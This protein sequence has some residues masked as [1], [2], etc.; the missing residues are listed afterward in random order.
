MSDLKVNKPVLLERLEERILL[1]AAPLATPDPAA[2]VVID[3]DQDFLINEEF[4]FSVTFENQSTTPTAV[5]FQPYVDVIVP[6]GIDIVSTSGAAQVG[7]TLYWDAVDGQWEDASDGSGNAVTDHPITLQPLA[8]AANDGDTL[9]IFEY[10]FGS[11]VPGQPQGE[12]N[13]VAV[14]DADNAGDLGDPA[15]V[16]MALDISA[17]GGFARGD[18]Q[19]FVPGEEIVGCTDTEQVTPQIIELVK[20]SD[21]PEGE[22][23]TGENYPVTFT[24]E[25]DVADG[26]TVNNLSILDTFTPIDGF[27]ITAPV[28]VVAVGGQTPDASSDLDAS[29]GNISIDFA[30]FTAD[31]GDDVV[32]VIVTYTGYFADIVPDDDGNFNDDL[33]WTNDS[34]ASVDFEGSNFVDDDDN[35][36]VEIELGIFKTQKSVAVTNDIGATGAT[37]GDTLTYTLAFQVSDFTSLKNIEFDDLLG[38][39]LTYIGLANAQ[40][41]VTQ[42][43]ITSTGSIV[44]ANQ[45]AT[46]GAAAGTTDIQFR[47]SDQLILDNV[48]PNG[49]LVGGQAVDP[50]NNV[51]ATT[52]FITFEAVILQEFGG[53]VGDSSVDITDVLNNNVSSTVQATDPTGVVDGDIESDTSEVSIQID[54]GEVSKETIAIDGIIGNEVLGVGQPVTYQ[55]SFT[56]PTPDV[57]NFSLID[58]LPLP[59]FNVANIGALAFNATEFDGTVGTLPGIGEYAFTTNHNLG[60]FAGVDDGGEFGASPMLS[61]NTAANTYTFDFGS[62]DSTQTGEVTIELVF[63][64]PSEEVFIADGLLLTNQTLATYNDTITTPVTFDAITQ[65]G[66]AAPDIELTKSVVAVDRADLVDP[67]SLYG[68]SDAGTAPSGSAPFNTAV[69]TALLNGDAID[70]DLTGIDAGDTV[71]FAIVLHNTGALDAHDLVIS[72]LLP[73]G[74]DAPAGNLNLEIYNGAGVELTTTSANPEVDLF[75]AGIDIV[76][77]AG[78]APIG[79]L[80]AGFETMLTLDTMDDVENITGSNIIIITYDLVASADIQAATAQTNTARL[81]EYALL[82]GGLDLTNGSALPQWEDDATTVANT[83]EVAKFFVNS[84]EGSTAGNDLTIGEVATYEILV[85]VPE[86]EVPNLQL[87]DQVPAGLAYVAG[88]AQIITTAGAFGAASSANLTNDFNGNVSL[89]SATSGGT[90]GAPVV[91]DIVGMPGDLFAVENSGND[92]NS[93]VIR[94]DML[95]LDVAS[96]QDGVSVTNTAELTFTDNDGADNE[97]MPEGIT[98]DDDAIIDIVA[99]DLEILKDITPAIA[100]AGDTLTFTLT[101]NNNGTADAF[102]AVI[103]DFIDPSKFTNITAATTPAGFVFDFDGI[104][105][106]TVT[107]TANPGVGIPDG[108]SVVFTFTGQLTSG[109]L[110]GEVITNTANVTGDTLPGD[111]PNERDDTDDGSDTVTVA[112][113]EAV[114]NFI[115]TSIDD[116]SPGVDNDINEVVVGENVIYELVV[117]IPEGVSTDVSIADTLDAGLAFAQIVSIVASPGLT[118]TVGLGDFSDPVDAPGTVGTWLSSVAAGANNQAQVTTF[119]LGTVTNANNDN[120]SAET[121]TIRYEATVLNVLA[122]QSGLTLGNSAVVSFDVNGAS[123]SNVPVSSPTDVII[124]EPILNT[125][126][127]VLVNGGTTGDNGDTVV[128]TIRVDHDALSETAAYDIDFTDDIPDEIINILPGGFTVASNAGVMVGD[129]NFVA[130]TNVITTIGDIDLELGEFFEITITGEIDNTVTPGQTLTNTASTDYSS[131]DGDQNDN[132]AYVDDGSDE[133]RD[134]DDGEG[135]ALDDYS[136]DDDAVITIN[137]IAPVKS[138]VASSEASTTSPEVAIGEIVRYRLLV[139]IPE[140][141]LV[142]FQLQDRLPDGMIFLNDGSAFAAIVSDTITSTSTLPNDPAL[143]LSA[144]PGANLTAFALPDANVSSNTAANVDVYTSG[145]D[146]FFKLGDFVNTDS[147]ANA[148]FIIIEFN[149]LVENIAANQEGVPLTNDFIVLNNG[150]QLG[151]DSNDITVDIVEP[152]I[153]LEKVLDAPVPTDAGDTVSYTFTI[154]ASDAANTG[155]GF[156]INL[157]DSL[158]ANISLTGIVF[159]AGATDATLDTSA[160]DPVGTNGADINVAVDQ[161]DPGEVVTVTVTGTLIQATPVGL[162]VDNIADITYTSLPGDGTD[163]NPTGSMPPGD[164]GDADGERGGDGNGAND[165]NDDGD[166]TFTLDAPT[167]DKVDPV[168]TTYTIGDLVTYNILVTLPEGVTQNLVILDNLPVGLSFEPGSVSIITAAAASGGLLVNDYAGTIPGPAIVNTGGSGDDL[169]FTFGN[170]TTTSDNNDL[171]NTFVVQYQ[172]RVDNIATNVDGQTLQ[173][174]ADLQYTNPNDGLTVTVDDPTDPIIDIVEPL[175]EVEKVLDP[176]LTNIEAGDTVSYTITVNHDLTA[177]DVSTSGAFDVNVEDDISPLLENVTITALLN[178]VDVGPTGT[179]VIFLDV[180]GDIATMPNALDLGNLADELVITVTGT[181]VNTATPGDPQDIISNSVDIDWSSQDDDPGDPENTDERDEDD[182]YTATDAADDV[183]IVGSLDVEKTV[184]NAA[185]TIGDIL[186]YTLTVNVS[187]G[188]ITNLDIDDTLPTGFLYQANTAVIVNNGDITFPSVNLADLEASGNAILVGNVLQ[189][190][191]AS[192]LNPGGS[193]ATGNPVDNLDVDSFQIQYQVL[194]SDDAAINNGDT[195]T[196]SADADADGVLPDNDNE[197]DVD[198]E[199]PQLNITKVATDDTPHYGDI[200]TYTVR[201]EHVDPPSSTTAFDLIITDAIANPGLTFIDN[202][203]TITG[204]SLA[205][206]VVETIEVGT[207]QIN[208]D[209]LALGGFIEFTYQAQVTSDPATFVLGTVLD[210]TVD[211]DY[212]TQPG[213]DPNERDYEDDAEEEVTIV[214]ADL[215][216]VKDNGETELTPGGTTTYTLT[217]TNNGTDVATG[218]TVTDTLPP[219]LSFNAASGGGAETAAGSGVVVWNLPDIPVGGVVMITLTVDVDDPAPAGITD[220]TNSVEVEHDDVEP[221]PADNS[222]NDIDTLDGALDLAIDK[223]VVGGPEFAPGDPVQYTVTVT[224]IGNQNASGVIVSDIFPT[225]ELT[226]LS[227]GPDVVGMND[228]TFVSFAGGVITWNLATV[229]TNETIVLTVNAVVNNPLP[230]GTI[231]F[232]NSVTV[233]DDGTGNPDANLMNNNDSETSPTPAFP[234][235]AVEKTNNI[236]RIQPLDNVTYEILVQNLGNQNSV[237]V[238]VIDFVDVTIFENIT[239]SAMFLV[240]FDSVTGRVEW[241]IPAIMGGGLE[242]F[243]LTIN[244]DVKLNTPPGIDMVENTVTAMDDGT[245]GPDANPN[246][247]QSTDTDELI[248]FAFDGIRDEVFGDDEE[249]ELRNRV[250]E[251]FR[252]PLNITT[253]YSG[254]TEPGSTL[255]FMIFDETGNSLG[256]QVVVADTAGN[257]VANFGNVYITDVPHDMT[258]TEDQPVY[259]SSTQGS[260]NLRTYFA[261]AHHGQ[262]FF[263]HNP[264]VESVF[265]NTAENVNQ[266]IHHALTNPIQ[267]GW[268]NTYGYEALTSSTTTTQARE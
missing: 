47:L 201:V 27:I 125:D 90:N 134:G 141:T 68:F 265:S 132:S 251:R 239:P 62:F 231:E 1:N 40:Y 260:F 85:T 174:A 28:N 177:P 42:A 203:V 9:L 111:D 66:I 248:V 153:S 123:V 64:V 102:D 118:T 114:K 250:E 8:A 116:T 46:P 100:D 99:P 268:S 121:I 149:A 78:S 179:G 209:S 192:L 241:L 247:N 93:F 32:D 257:W 77:P 14:L 53:P 101:V 162:Q 113:P 157:T 89:V 178:G 253:F 70:S 207:V 117:T 264:T 154:T 159:N 135:G 109:V 71:R 195:E 24:L 266:S 160:S 67:E 82:E 255:K 76:D 63:T 171:N 225:D 21:A 86:G 41:S 258:V 242:Q 126:K 184:D 197:A 20:T 6:A 238:T 224:N 95:V 22:R 262:V 147:D 220:Y 218:V 11:F 104:T 138:I 210:N 208:A 186:T 52:G 130:G 182:G 69:T 54:G 44:A 55:L 33:L 217:I 128:Y 188:A 183:P 5:G 166:A 34:S 37:P 17:T 25:L 79:A 167:I 185:A 129:F 163:P 96:N 259:N 84:S 73:A 49:V 211:L 124:I 173:N 58:Y 18:D 119:D 226:F 30:S 193:N 110:A 7:P 12:I 92:D 249:E 131:E 87:A 181:V 221:T 151:P 74:Y 115:G 137:Q 228:H 72:D 145:T 161:L 150:S 194:V 215:A 139:E 13:F 136:D 235:I 142:D 75:G 261:P 31:A 148:E 3:P 26:Q 65:I 61:M 164:S 91:F 38:D 223:E 169:T 39:G 107:Y 172:S 80:G 165:Y 35:T 133:E 45:T 156:D 140:T 10:P 232:T 175:L 214:G 83:P 213:D 199:E 19:N 230:D 219:G 4:D 48:D 152:D 205:I 60:D 105:T 202:S 50:L 98:L 263:L 122:N 229:E 246:N 88:S 146:V 216:I 254:W 155:P 245:N 16:S 94:F 23:T 190:D 196:N 237:N 243:V 204:S 189:I 198:I 106:D 187:E 191:I 43:G 112:N 59:V 36:D 15:E 170:S 227:V 206:G 51:G 144:D 81:E 212:D 267:L 168:P 29:D 103:T 120:A 222:D 180:N 240:S 252:D 233:A 200:V 57:E 244:A 143:F 176:V 2:D 108:G 127:T 236:D 158:D 56:F 256:E 234:D 97:S